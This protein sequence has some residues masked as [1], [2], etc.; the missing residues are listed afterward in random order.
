M[1]TDMRSTAAMLV[2]AA[3]LVLAAS[4]TSA[5]SGTGGHQASATGIPRSV[6]VLS[7]VKPA[8]GPW[9]FC[10][11]QVCDARGRA[12]FPQELNVYDSGNDIIWPTGFRKT[13][14][15]AG[16]VDARGGWES[17]GDVDHDGVIEVFGTF[18]YRIRFGT[19]DGGRHWRPLRA[20]YSFLDYQA[21]TTDTYEP[22]LRPCQWSFYFDPPLR[23]FLCFPEAQN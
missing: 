21:D 16:V 6:F 1:N 17:W 9:H 14:P 7:K 15:R 11:E 5:W 8:S 12:I 20:V 22:A 10:K 18:E 3:G 19:T 13:G 2:L 4:A 23:V